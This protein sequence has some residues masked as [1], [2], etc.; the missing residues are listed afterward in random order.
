MWLIAGGVLAAL[1]IWAVVHRRARAAEPPA[2][3]PEPYV[4]TM[5]NDHDCECEKPGRGKEESTDAG[6]DEDHP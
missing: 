5:C 3:K 1:I 2:E 6:S 4:C